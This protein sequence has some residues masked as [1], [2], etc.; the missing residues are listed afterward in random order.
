MFPF[1]GIS[2]SKPR[3]E[4]DGEWTWDVTWWWE[5]SALVAQDCCSNSYSFNGQPNGH[6]S[7]H[8]KPFLLRP[9]S[10][11]QVKQLRRSTW[12]SICGNNRG[13]Q[14]NEDWAA[15][16]FAPNEQ[17]DSS[18]AEYQV[19]FQQMK[20]SFPLVAYGALHQM[21]M[22]RIAELKANRLEA[23]HERNRKEEEE[24]PLKTNLASNFNLVG[25]VD[26]FSNTLAKHNPQDPDVN[27]GR[28]RSSISAPLK[29]DKP[30]SG[31]GLRRGSAIGNDSSPSLWNRQER[32]DTLLRKSAPPSFYQAPH[33]HSFSLPTKRI[34]STAD[35]SSQFSDSD[36]L[37]FNFEHRMSDKIVKE[38]D[39]VNVFGT[40]H[41]RSMSDLSGLFI[42]DDDDGN[43]NIDASD[44]YDDKGL[45]SVRSETKL[46]RS[47]D[48]ASQVVDG[49]QNDTDDNISLSFNAPQ[50]IGLNL[51]L[52]S[53]SDE[54][55]SSHH[56]NTMSFT[57]D[58]TLS[59]CCSTKSSNGL[60]VGFS[61][62]RTIYDGNDLIVR[63][64]KEE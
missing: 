17:L 26:F 61:H 40:S 19:M 15:P 5:R 46:P 1:A 3:S 60:I 45:Y 41:R 37:D 35:I 7:L 30:Y 11:R 10:S 34:A 51:S 14:S 6:Q 21:T 55:D 56:A 25:M 36:N 8:S 54:S 49:N 44:H 4:G 48:A 27:N 22:A 20:H 42:D 33:S 12:S 52:S 31:D 32:A 16:A 29:Q 58:L 62:Q 18:L 2:N 59:D 43:K 13:N 63:F 50:F 57:S 38:E 24:R 9:A 53:K 47:P 39:Y 28:L 64:V 23:Q